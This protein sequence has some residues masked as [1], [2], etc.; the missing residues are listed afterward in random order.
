MRKSLTLFRQKDA[1]L[2]ERVFPLP[3]RE[4]V[5][6]RGVVNRPHPHLY[7]LPSRERKFFEFTTYAIFSFILAAFNANAGQLD[8]P[9]AQKS[10]VCSA[11]HGFG[12]NAPGQHVPKLAGMNANYFKK[13][14]KDY[15]EGK[16]PSPEMEPYAK[17]VMQ[18]GID[19]IADYFAKQ[20][21]PAAANLKIDAKSVSRG[22]ALGSQCVAC[23]GANGDGDGDKMIPAL[24]GQPAGFLRNQMTLFAGD[25]RKLDD[26]AVEENKKRIFKGLAESDLTDLAAYYASLK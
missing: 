16:R 13:A 4:R 8:S 15:A 25:K 24:R 26:P 10:L 21:K 7:P 9:G 22:A 2:H 14:V 20:K 3:L 6:V 11:C 12:G 19:E 1:L 23:H 17:Y 18:F 5:R